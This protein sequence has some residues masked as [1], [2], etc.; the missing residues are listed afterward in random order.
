MKLCVRQYIVNNLIYM[1]VCV[2]VCVLTCIMLI[3]IVQNMIHGYI[4]DITDNDSWCDTAK[5][6]PSLRGMDVAR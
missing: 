1:C 2:C 4:T 6:I 5:W 3:V